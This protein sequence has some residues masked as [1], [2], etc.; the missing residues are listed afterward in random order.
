MAVVAVSFMFS[1]TSYAIGGCVDIPEGA[2]WGKTNHSK[3]AAYVERR[4]EGDWATYI[5]KWA[6]QLKTM[7]SIAARGGSAVFKKK[8]LTLKGET[9]DDYVTALKV[10]VAAIECLSRNDDM[11]QAARRMSSMETAAGGK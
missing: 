5:N 1:S 8:G 10:R 9:L 3:I 2:W 7:K 6:R 4:H 11:G